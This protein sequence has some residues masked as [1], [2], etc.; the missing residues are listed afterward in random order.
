RDLGIFRR[1]VVTAS[2]DPV[3]DVTVELEEA[4]PFNVA[5]DARYNNQDRLNGSVDGQVQ[6]LFGRAVALGL[7]VQAGRYIREGRASL[8]LPT[9]W[10][11]GDMTISAY[12][13][14]QTIRTAFGAAGSA[15]P[16]PLERDLREERGM[17]LQQAVHRFHPFEILYGY[18]YR[19]LT[20]PGQG[21][22][23]L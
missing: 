2:A 3:A 17:Q 1:A 20:C 23:P 4:A 6:N 10:H 19:R 12:D 21:L 11:L 22:P 18:R 14:R 16:P 9:V 15:T 13:L 7:R 8:H 5:Y